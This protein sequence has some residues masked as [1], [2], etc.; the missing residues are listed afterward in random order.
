MNKESQVADNEKNHSKSHAISNMKGVSVGLFSPDR[1]ERYC[2]SMDVGDGIMLS[3]HKQQQP[4]PPP[5]SSPQ[6]EIAC[7]Q[8]EE[9][10]AEKRRVE[11][12]DDFFPADETRPFINLS[13]IRSIEEETHKS[14]SPVPS[15][16]RSAVKHSSMEDAL[17]IEAMMTKESDQEL[18]D[19][20][21]LRSTSDLFYT[22]LDGESRGL[23]MIL[24]V[25]ALLDFLSFLSPSLLRTDNPDEKSKGST[26]YLYSYLF[27]KVGEH[28]DDAG[29]IRTT[30]HF[31]EKHGDSIGLIFS[32]L[33][34]LFAF[35]K[36]RRTRDWVL[37][38]RDK[39]SL[40]QEDNENKTDHDA[41][42]SS[43][44]R[45]DSENSNVSSSR[46]VENISS[47]HGIYLLMVTWQLL[48]LPVGF[49]TTVYQVITGD[50]ADY[51]IHKVPKCV[52]EECYMANIVTTKFRQSALYVFVQQGTHFVSHRVKEEVK[53]T[54][55]Q[56]FAQLKRFLMR[57][58]IRHPLEF[59]KKL[60][61]GLQW[62]R[63]IRYLIPLIGGVNKLRGNILDL[64]KKRRQRR[65]KDVLQRCFLELQDCKRLRDLSYSQQQD[66]A[67][68]IIQTAWRTRQRRKQIRALKLLK[69]DPEIIATIKLQKHFRSWLERSRAR[70]KRKRAELAFLQKMEKNGIGGRGP[71]I[72][73]IQRRR[74]YRLQEELAT[75]AKK[76]RR[77]QMLLY[78]NTRWAV[79]W[80]YIF[81]ACLIVELGQKMM[82]PKLTHFAE[83]VAA[84]ERRKIRVE[85]MDWATYLGAKI[86]PKQIAEWDECGKALQAGE[87]MPWYCQRPWAD[88]HVA[89]IKTLE[90]AIVE[91]LAFIS[92]VMFCDV[93]VSFFTGELD[94]TG[95]LV[96]KPWFKR[97]IL[98]GVAIQLLLNPRMIE[99]SAATRAL[100]R[101]TYHDVGPITAYRWLSALFLPAFVFMSDRLN[102]HVWCRF[103]REENER[104]RTN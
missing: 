3:L 43:L 51:G 68:L 49:Y 29:P 16:I 92:F 54:Y 81:V 17:T 45:F 15:F 62:I 82:K 46:L 94:V 102:R 26:Q 66:H 18:Q 64:L 73:A 19:E 25:A 44:K 38:M 4:P 50:A 65:E 24:A 9:H 53:T 35:G 78:P 97:W 77:R 85:D 71:H 90:V 36:A 22:R 60:R 34:F 2:K 89:Y 57:F 96:P 80:K 31:L 76:R 39:K 10:R 84:A 104:S 72:S 70:L 93:F 98:P 74:M 40:L 8:Q 37:R 86:L 23:N 1:K 5:P 20:E 67:P 52:G 41:N 12:E 87:I 75:T 7:S 28:I 100:I 88:I 11:G 69:Q 95:E 14:T 42:S 48:L 101:H 6:P 58:V 83:E 56:R 33:W 79:I 21:L 61:K 30:L 103:V 59:R 63:W 32:V 99:I 27:S 13:P 55:L 47:A 91:S